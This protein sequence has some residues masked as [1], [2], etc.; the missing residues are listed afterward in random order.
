LRLAFAV[1]KKRLRTLL[2]A[3]LMIIV[4]SIL[5]LILFIVPGVI[6][7][8]NSALTA[9]VV[10]ME[11][12]KPRA[13][14]R[15]SKELVRR[16]RRTVIGVLALQYLIPI[17]TSSVFATMFSLAAKAAPEQKIMSAKLTTVVTHTLNVFIVPLIA[18]LGSL[19]YLKT[20]AAGGESLTDA[21]AEIEEE[22]R[23]TRQWEL[24]IRERMHS[25]TS[26]IR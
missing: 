13:A 11:N 26:A 20:R 10:M 1:L 5:G 22:E 21:L 2:L 25:S 14:R 4:G 12:L 7:Y 8:I 15:R 19:L 16:A 17:L 23:P 18:T 9:P 3:T 6:Y 24:R